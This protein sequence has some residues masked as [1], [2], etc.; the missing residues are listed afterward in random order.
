MPDAI[1]RK[2]K[3]VIPKADIDRLFQL[4]PSDEVRRVLSFADAMNVFHASTDKKRCAMEIA[5]RLEPLGIRGI[6]L[7]RSTERNMLPSYQTKNT[8]GRKFAMSLNW[9]TTDSPSAFPGSGSRLTPNLLT[10][11][12][13]AS[14]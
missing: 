4:L 8:P 10:T 3:V 11:G 14:S 2:P 9:S 7:C 12:T 1:I 6:S 13:R 5:E